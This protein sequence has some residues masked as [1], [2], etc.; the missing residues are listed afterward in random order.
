MKPILEYI[1]NKSTRLHKI[2]AN[3]G[4]IYNLFKKLSHNR[5][6]KLTPNMNAAL[7]DFTKFTRLENDMLKEHILYILK[8][9][10]KAIEEGYILDY[11]D[12]IDSYYKYPDGTKEIYLENTKTISINDRYDELYINFVDMSRLMIYRIKMSETEIEVTIYHSGIYGK[13]SFDIFIDSINGGGLKW[14]IDYSTD[15]KPDI[16]RFKETLNKRLGL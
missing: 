4:T 11:N 1:I 5:L 3:G 12:D 6:D 9:I 10:D 2:E 16:E 14:E 8:A 13:N 7:D 15:V